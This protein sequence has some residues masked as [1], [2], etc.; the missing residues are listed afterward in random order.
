MTRLGSIAKLIAGFIAFGAAFA[1]LAPFDAAQA[2]ECT[3]G[4]HPMDPDCCTPDKYG[5][6]AR[7]LDVGPQ[8]LARIHGA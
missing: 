7:T 6:A 4:L 1:T 5:T 3:P 8:S 2:Q